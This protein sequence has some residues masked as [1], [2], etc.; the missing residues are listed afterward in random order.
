MSVAY[1]EWTYSDLKR[2]V[3]ERGLEVEGDARQ[4][5]NLIRALEQDDAPHDQ[6]P[7][8]QGQ[9]V[10]DSGTSLE[11]RLASIVPSHSGLRVSRESGRSLNPVNDQMRV[12]N[13]PARYVHGWPSL[14][15]NGEDLGSWLALGWVRVT[16]DMVT[17]NPHDSSKIYV[18]S[19]EDWSGYVKYKDCVLVIAD[20]RLVEERKKG[21][22][23]HWNAKVQ[24][25]YGERGELTRD[26]VGDPSRGSGRSFKRAAQWK[27]EDMM[28]GEGN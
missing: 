28:N 11:E 24:K 1:E 27:A 20:R 25:T 3:D 17:S 13:L 19:Y 26:R 14:V 4:K 6:E 9:V 23:D 15:G 16:T 10:S 2:E 18:Q 7:H 12:G 5:A 21:H 8:D 22:A